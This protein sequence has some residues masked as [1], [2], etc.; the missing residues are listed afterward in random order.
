[1]SS[2]RFRTNSN[3]VSR[4]QAEYISTGINLSGHNGTIKIEQ[5]D[6]TDV[7]RTVAEGDCKP[8]DIFHF[9]LEGGRLNGRSAAAEFTNFYPTVYG[10]TSTFSHWTGLPGSPSDTAVATN[11]AART[12]PSRP[13]VDVPRA[14][15]ELFDV[16]QLIRQTGNTLIKRFAK[17]HITGA[18]GLGPLYSDVMKLNNFAQQLDQRLKE[19]KRLQTKN[20][21]RKTTGHGTYSKSGPWTRVFQSQGIYY[22]GVFQ[23]NTVEEVTCHTRWIPSGNFSFLDAKSLRVLTHDIMLGMRSGKVPI[24]DMSTIWELIPWTWLLDW[25]GTV[26]QYFIA[27]RNI[28][29]CS[30][31]GAYV[32]RHT[33]SVTSHPGARL[34]TGLIL[35]PVQVTYEQK[36]RK[37]GLVAPT[38]QFPL[39]SGSQLGIIASLSVLRGR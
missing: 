37:Q 19:M 22:E 4:G 3:V 30:F 15:G 27:Q 24:V 11:A 21:F 9:K 32:M 12:N 10:Q 1:M 16:V 33:K 7:V 38:A 39:L 31:A 14:V 29:P 36:S 26:G 34:G 5:N 20:G 35:E 2:T 23:T 25:A 18:F 28:V 17:A 8:L 6:C 13:Y